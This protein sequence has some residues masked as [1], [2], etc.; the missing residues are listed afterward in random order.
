MIDQD[1][2]GHF[3][4]LMGYIT[5]AGHNYAEL[6]QRVE[7]QISQTKGCVKATEKIIEKRKVKAMR[8]T[9]EDFCNY[10]AGML[11]IV[12]E[13]EWLTSKFGEEGLYQA[14]LGLCKI[15]TIQEIEEKN[16]S[17]TP[18]AYVGVAEVEDNGVDFH[19]RMNEIHTELAQ[20]N[21]EANTLMGEIQT[22]WK[23]LKR[24]E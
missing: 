7:S 12:D 16:Y 19:E 9:G 21:T 3:L 13:H 22:A 8:Q 11:K 14:I 5:E 1:T 20:L 18:G 6:K 17:L 4:G 15:A 23:E 2:R 24:E 10:L